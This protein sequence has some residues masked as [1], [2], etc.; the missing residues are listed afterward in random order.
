[1]NARSDDDGPVAVITGAAG[2]IGAALTSTLRT[3]GYRVVGFDLGPGPAAGPSVRTVDVTCSAEV[4]AGVSWAV[5]Q[6]GRID[7]LVNNAGIL[8]THALHETSEEEWDRVLAV[9]LK[10]VYLTCRAVIPILRSGGGG[11]IVNVS[12]V[13]ALASIPHTSAYAASKGGL[14]SLSRQ[15]AVEYAD[16]RIRVNSVV[17]GSVDT[18]MSAAH[19]EALA[20]DGIVLSQFPGELGR[21]AEPA[22]VARAIAFLLSPDASFVNGST[23][24][25]DGGMLARLM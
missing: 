18:G 21:Q 15:L 9:N 19:G 23:V 24:V 17:V 12:S 11:T 3:R 2:G 13:H 5:D 14:L 4:A 8:A 25:V 7:A 20:R 22:E 6:Y 16:D 1:M 10:G